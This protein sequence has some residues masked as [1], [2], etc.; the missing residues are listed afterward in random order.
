MKYTIHISIVI[1]VV[2]LYY[3]YNHVYIGINTHCKIC[4]IDRGS[5]YH[6]IIPTTFANKLN[7]ASSGKHCLPSESLSSI[8]GLDDPIDRLEDALNDIIPENANQR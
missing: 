2:A 3:V 8:L 7:M 1:I 6:Y 5:H 4:K